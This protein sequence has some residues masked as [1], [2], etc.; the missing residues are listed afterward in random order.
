ML[1]F[2]IFH[3]VFFK[4]KSLV[5]F[6]VLNQKFNFLLIKAHNKNIFY[7]IRFI[8]NLLFYIFKKKNSNEIIFKKK[9]RKKIGISALKIYFTSLVKNLSAVKNKSKRSFLKKVYK[10]IKFKIKRNKLNKQI[11]L[12]IIIRYFRIINTLSNNIDKGN[13]LK[14]LKKLKNLKFK[15]NSRSFKNI[16]I[17]VGR[18]IH[19][20]LK[21]NVNPG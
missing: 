13:G 19:T 15:V 10:K 11:Y 8:K 17:G 20:K 12:S 3:K 14:N 16:T 9:N 18:L 21:V 2:I 4:G 6:N 7:F 5:K 1:I